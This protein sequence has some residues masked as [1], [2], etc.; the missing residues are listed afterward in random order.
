MSRTRQYDDAAARAGLMATF[1]EKGFSAASLVDLETGSGLN[2]RQLYND[3][4]DKKA[5]FL[6]ALEDFGDVAGRLILQPLENGALGVADIRQTLHGMLALADTER[7]R[8]GCLICNTARE[9]VAEDADVRRVVD[10]F[11]R[12]IEAA[13]GRALTRAQDRQELAADRDV[14][15]LARLFMAIH[16]SLSVMARAGTKVA[17]LEDVVM[18][19]LEGLS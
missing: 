3:Y 6:R 5:V 19:S 15:R 1:L 11:F 13:Y 7:G 8:L 9:P 12:R 17:V 4:G 16:V 2:R 10:A 18:E 14:G